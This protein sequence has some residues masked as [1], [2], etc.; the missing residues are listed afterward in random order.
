MTTKVLLPMERLFGLKATSMTSTVLAS[1][2]VSMMK[3]MTA[4]ATS[5]VMRS[6]DLSSTM[7]VVTVLLTTDHQRHLLGTT[8]LRQIR[9]QEPILLRSAMTTIMLMVMDAH[10][11]APSSLSMSALSG[12]SHARFYVETVG[13]R[14]TKLK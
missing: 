1:L 4:S 14:S 8:N 10:L 6:A 9:D 3:M 12:A 11:L 13:L 7:A 5:L 2:P